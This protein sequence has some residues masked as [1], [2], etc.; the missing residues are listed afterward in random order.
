ADGASRVPAGC[1]EVS[2]WTRTEQVVSQQ[3]AGRFPGGRGRSKSCPSRVRGG[4]RVD[5]DGA[6]RVPAGCGEVSGWTR[7]EQV[8]SQQ[9]AG[10]FP[11]GR[12][13]SKSCPSRVRGG[14]RVDTDGAS[15]VPAGC[16]E[17]FG[18]RGLSSIWMAAG[19]LI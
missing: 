9:G 16:G 10:R 7:T 6:S 12:G 13:R 14:F 19:L 3:G 17:V 18:R 8:V 5:A 11:G 15:R 2:G 1:G 4:F